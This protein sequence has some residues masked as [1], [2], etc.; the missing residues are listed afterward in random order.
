MDWSFGAPNSCSDTE[1]RISVVTSINNVTIYSSKMFP[2]KF[3]RLAGFA[4][5]RCSSIIISYILRIFYCSQFVV[6]LYPSLR[7]IY[8]LYSIYIRTLSTIEQEGTYQIIS[9]SNTVWPKMGK[10][11]GFSGQRDRAKY[12][13]MNIKIPYRLLEASGLIRMY[14]E[15]LTDVDI[16]LSLQ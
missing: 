2:A 12:L 1:T 9:A 7:Y 5:S 11:T 4:E 8:I 3:I 14:Y 6:N 13:L 10:F 16:F 15:Q